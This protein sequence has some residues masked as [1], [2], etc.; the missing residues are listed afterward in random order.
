MDAQCVSVSVTGFRFLGDLRTY[1]QGPVVSLVL[2]CV[3]WTIIFC[4][5]HRLWLFV[6]GRHRLEREQELLCDHENRSKIE[7]DNVEQ[8]L[9]LSTPGDELDAAGGT[10][11]KSPVEAV[12]VLI[13]VDNKSGVDLSG[14]PLSLLDTASLLRVP[15]EEVTLLQAQTGPVVQTKWAQCTWPC[16]PATSKIQ[17][18]EKKLGVRFL[19]QLG[20]RH[21]LYRP[22]IENTEWRRMELPVDETNQVP[23]IL[24]SSYS[25][26][27]LTVEG[28]HLTEASIQAAT[29]D[30]CV[31][32]KT[33]F[34]TVSI[35][36]SLDLH[37][38]IS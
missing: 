5:Y 24:H 23:V 31:N 18:I 19:L 26:G 7:K 8:M 4:V 15:G 17:A 6:Q 37:P 22:S 10:T 38:L 13:S 16:E 9:S 2:Y 35:L 25:G 20:I 33:K 21:L 3:V 27:T 30:K 28:L 32:L 11:Q 12:P 14:A 1:A 36:H 34:N 29:K